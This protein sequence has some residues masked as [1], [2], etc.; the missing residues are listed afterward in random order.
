MIINQAKE[1]GSI[2]LAVSGELTAIT[3]EQLND[4]IKKAIEETNC[5]IL[6]FKDLEYVASAGLRVLL[7]AKKLMDARGGK[8]IVRQVCEAVM[9]VFEITGFSDILVIQ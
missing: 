4:A 8:F 9:D 7:Q 2:I 3:S 1:N 5:L 6:D